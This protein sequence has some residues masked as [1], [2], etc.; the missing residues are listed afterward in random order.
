MTE[1]HVPA[2][3]VGVKCDATGCDASLN[4]SP[5]CEWFVWSK[6]YHDMLRGSGWTEW[7][8]RGRRQYCPDHGPKDGHSMR[9]VLPRSAVLS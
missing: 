2:Y 3:I 8:G 6:D 5:S 7:A 9:Q 1:L 4:I